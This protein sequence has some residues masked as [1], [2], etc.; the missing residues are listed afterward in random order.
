MRPSPQRM[1]VSNLLTPN[2][3]NLYANSLTANSF[4]TNALAVN[5]NLTITNGSLLGA[6][7][8]PFASLTTTTLIASNLST[9][10]FQVL[11]VGAVYSITLPAFTQGGLSYTFIVGS[12]A[13]SNIVTI[14]VPSGALLSGVVSASGSNL[15]CTGTKTSVLLAPACINGD[16]VTITSVRS[17]LYTI[18][19][20]TATAGGITFA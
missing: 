18:S 3:L 4:T 17:N 20:F 11:N 5:G 14:I 1:S 7:I 6:Q 12:L 19:G 9:G 10:V 15:V 2:N 13:L 8:P 16:T